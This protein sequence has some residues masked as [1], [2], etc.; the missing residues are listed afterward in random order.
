M[1][2]RV[3]R[4]E[5][6]LSAGTCHVCELLRGQL[7]LPSSLNLDLR[8][9][10]HCDGLGCGALGLDGCLLR[11]LWLLLLL[12]RS[13]YF[14]FALP[15]RLAL[16]EVVHVL[17]RT[18]VFLLHLVLLRHQFHRNILASLLACLHRVPDHLYALGRLLL[19]I[20]SHQVTLS[21]V[22]DLLVSLGSSGMW[23]RER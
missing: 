13:S 8:F 2:L 11:L 1:D 7:R 22:L 3:L 18:V 21:I 23:T 16:S 12:L 4:V 14:M 9:F 5:L 15:L 6:L 20:Q 17:F 10:F 19:L